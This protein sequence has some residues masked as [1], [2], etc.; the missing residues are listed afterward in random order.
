MTLSR[1]VAQALVHAHLGGHPLDKHLLAAAVYVAEDRLRAGMLPVISDLLRQDLDNQMETSAPPPQT[2]IACDAIKTATGAEWT[3]GMNPVSDQVDSAGRSTA[4][5]VI[6]D[7]PIMRDAIASVLRRLR[8]DARISEFGSLAEVP[9]SMSSLAP[10]LAIILDLNLPD[11]SGYSGVLHIRRL[12]PYTPLAV[13]SASPASEMENKCIAAGA[14]LY[15]SKATGSQKL[16]AAL[17]TLLSKSPDVALYAEGDQ[18]LRVR[19]GT[20][21]NASV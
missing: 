4:I 11:A 8:A 10:P 2:R 21:A 16:T 5:Y 20:T 18:P 3:I 12:Y 13:Y 15:I 19:S 14:D 9:P 6:D 17:K 7:H 1:T